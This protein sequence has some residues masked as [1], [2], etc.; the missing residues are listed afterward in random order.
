MFSNP[1]EL[2]VAAPLTTSSQR[3]LGSYTTA[4]RGLRAETVP[5]SKYSEGGGLAAVAEFYG[6]HEGTMEFYNPLS[7]EPEPPGAH[8][9]TWG[10]LRGRLCEVGGLK[11]CLACMEAH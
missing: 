8:Q 5:R 3:L 2:L 7:P 9:S 11:N 1:S 10:T 6:A 4:A